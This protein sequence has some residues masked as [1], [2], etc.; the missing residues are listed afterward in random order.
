MVLQPH[1][2]KRR[3]ETRSIAILAAY[4]ASVAR[5][6][7]AA[8]MIFSL[9]NWIQRSRGRMLPLFKSE[10]GKLWERRWRVSNQKAGIIS[11]CTDELALCGIRTIIR[12]P[13]A[14]EDLTLAL[15]ALCA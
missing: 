2:A 7:D 11:G 1:A 15:D 10:H 3:R 9:C 13:A 5:Y 6:A 8:P 14:L 4:P 12:K